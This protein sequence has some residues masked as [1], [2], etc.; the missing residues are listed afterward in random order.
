MSKQIPNITDMCVLSILY[1]LKKKDKYFIKLA[2]EYAFFRIRIYGLKAK[3][4]EEYEQQKENLKKSYFSK[5]KKNEISTFNKIASEEYEK[6]KNDPNSE[7][8]D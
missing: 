8:Y 4:K 5:I 7:Y 6:L 1:S 2:N 3:N